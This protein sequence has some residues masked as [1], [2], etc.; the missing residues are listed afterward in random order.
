MQRTPTKSAK[1]N[2]S[3]T[4]SS[5]AKRVRDLT[6]ESPPTASKNQ[7]LGSPKT[8]TLSEYGVSSSRLLALMDRKFAKQNEIISTQISAQITL[9]LEQMQQQILSE[10]GS[11]IDGLRNELCTVTERV[12]KLEDEVSNVHILKSEVAALKTQMAKYENTT[13]ACDLR[14]NG[15]PYEKNENLMSIFQTLCNTMQIAPPRV[16]NMFRVNRVKNNQNNNNNNINRTYTDG[17]ILIK[18][19]TPSDKNFLLKTIAIYKRNKGDLLRL[20]DAGFNSDMPIYMN[21][22]LTKTNHSILQLAVRMKRQKKLYSVFT[23]R[24]LIN[25]KLNENDTSVCIDS[26]EKLCEIT[27]TNSSMTNNNNAFADT[28]SLF[29]S[30]AHSNENNQHM[31]NEK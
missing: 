2:M 3:S 9:K 14:L 24:G 31:S 30:D 22:S 13:V 17:T 18:V 20:H 26:I 12:C 27:D 29:R 16:V 19:A 1:E 25:V 11:K 10:L 5:A 28:G 7:K 21:E 6:S 15:V 8:P 4:T 23:L